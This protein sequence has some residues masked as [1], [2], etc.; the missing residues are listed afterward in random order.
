M[1][2]WKAEA[3]QLAGELAALETASDAGDDRAERGLRSILQE[4]HGPRRGAKR[5]RGEAKKASDDVAAALAAAIKDVAAKEDILQALVE[6][7]DK[8]RPPWP[9]SCPT[10]RPW[11]MRPSQFKTRAGEIDAQLAAARKVVVE[12]TPQVQAASLKLAE[13]DKTAASRPGRRRHRARRARRGRRQ[14]HGRAGKISHGQGPAR[15]S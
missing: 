1:A 11:P 14:G 15:A 13:A 5:S 4:R 7:R 3:Q 10:T 8:A 9:P 6:A 12:K 2:A